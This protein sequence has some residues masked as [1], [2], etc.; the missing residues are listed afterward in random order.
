MPAACVVDRRALLVLERNPEAV[1]EPLDGRREVEPLGLLDEADH[2]AALAA[3][4]A[5]E[6]LLDRVDGKARR[7][8]LVER[9]APS[10]ARAGLPQRRALLDDGDEVCTL[11]DRL[12]ARVL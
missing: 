10:E 4:E 9:A 1:G 7:A 6:E 12:D 3:A 5:V 11:P 2:V 8:L